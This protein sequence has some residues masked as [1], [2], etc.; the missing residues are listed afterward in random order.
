LDYLYKLFNLV[1]ASQ[2]SVIGDP[3]KRLLLAT[4]FKLSNCLSVC[5]VN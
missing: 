4:C 2:S 5:L 1:Y 3:F